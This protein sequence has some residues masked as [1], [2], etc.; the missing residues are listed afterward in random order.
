VTE[1]VIELGDKKESGTREDLPFSLPTSWAMI[2]QV[3]GLH[4]ELLA[5]SHC[6]LKPLQAYRWK[7]TVSFTRIQLQA[8]DSMMRS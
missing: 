7:S 3:T 6:G 2:A 1:R 5:E 8:T 4:P